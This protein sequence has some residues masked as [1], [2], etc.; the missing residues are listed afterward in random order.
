MEKLQG[1]EEVWLITGGLGYI[2]AHVAR[3]LMVSGKRIVILDNLSTGL[4]ER[5]PKGAEFVQGDARSSEVIRKICNRFNVSGIVHM[6]AHKHARESQVDPAKYFT[7]NVGATIG[8]VE[9]LQ[10]TSVKKVIFSSSC[11]IYGNGIANDKSLP[12]PQSP[13]AQSKLICETILQDS[14]DVMDISFISLR[15]FNVIGCADFLYSKD[16]SH[17]CLVPV[18]NR[19]IAEGKPIEIFGTDL[20]TPDGTC[21]RDYLDVRDI[22]NAH[23]LI[24]NQ[25]SWGGFPSKL[26]LSSGLPTSVKDVVREF[27]HALGRSIEVLSM[28]HNLADPISIWA[29]PSE[30]LASLGWKPR[31]TLRESI[32]SHI[33][34]DIG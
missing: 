17:E 4:M 33:Q 34:K 24:A 22:A 3:E 15:F 27:E 2:G 6:A 19:K 13:Y 7:N 25:T 29:E 31:F 18:L 32:E 28:D 1:E 9:G 23:A 5:L 16:Q 10:R 8:L 30:F 20:S 26:N 12:N 14:L 21:Q 11:S